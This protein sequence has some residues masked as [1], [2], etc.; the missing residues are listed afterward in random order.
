M[1]AVDKRGRTALHGRRVLGVAE[2]REMTNWTVLQCYLRYGGDTEGSWR[3]DNRTKN[4]SFC[5]NI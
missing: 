5:G 2:E 4:T 1:T 3:Y